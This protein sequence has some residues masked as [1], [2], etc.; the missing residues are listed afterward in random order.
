MILL[1]LSQAQ[2]CGATQRGG[3]VESTS[4][5]QHIMAKEL[6]KIHVFCAM[7][8][9]KYIPKNAYLGNVLEKSRFR[10]GSTLMSV[11]FVNKYFANP[12]TFGNIKKLGLIRESKRG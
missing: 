10:D 2:R 5:Q 3:R 11:K 6:F 1:L 12:S 4:C 7:Q 8:G 9:E